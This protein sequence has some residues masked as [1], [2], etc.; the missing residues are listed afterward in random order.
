MRFDGSRPIF[1]QIVDMISEAVLSGK[2]VDRIPS[3]REIATE[4]E[5]NPNTVARAYM[6][7]QDRGVI[8]MK[9]GMGY[10]VALDGAELVLRARKLEFVEKELPSIF[11]T[12][13]LL[14]FSI[15]EIEAL[16]R[17]YKEKNEG[18]KTNSVQRD[19]MDGLYK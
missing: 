17:E 8:I 7:L 16:Y 1:M 6:L 11:K 5:V 3:V 2:Y 14:G 18:E 19:S 12:V 13:D 10:Y 15:S 9:R 4:L